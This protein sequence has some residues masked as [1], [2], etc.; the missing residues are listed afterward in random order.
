METVNGQ[1]MHC[2]ELFIKH[3][4]YLTIYTINQTVST[5]KGDS[6]IEES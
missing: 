2:N 1:I 5:P 4:I 6:N 3:C